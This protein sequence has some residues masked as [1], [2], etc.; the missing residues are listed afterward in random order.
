MRWQNREGSNNIE[1]AR[2]R[3]GGGGSGGGKPLGIIGF[4]ILLIGAYNGVDLSGLVGGANQLGNTQQQQTQR[5]QYSQQEQQL[6]KLSAVVLRET[7]KVWGA[8]FQKMGKT[9]Q[10]PVLRI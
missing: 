8:Y 3:S 5:P 2:G 4:I 6:Y 1:D 10:E 9:Y 7:E